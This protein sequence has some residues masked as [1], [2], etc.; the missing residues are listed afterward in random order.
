MT[1]CN[2]FVYNFTTAAKISFGQN[3]RTS[4]LLRSLYEGNAATFSSLIRE[5]KYKIRLVKFFTEV[6]YNLLYTKLPLH[7]SE[8]K[9]LRTHKT[10][11]R[12]LA[13]KRGALKKDIKSRIV[14]FLENRS[15]LRIIIAIFLSGSLSNDA[16]F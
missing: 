15:L 16:N 3:N 12:L 14:L 7:D 10:V 6:S 8:R 9:K 11:L 2:H 13:V 1:T 5:T 4:S